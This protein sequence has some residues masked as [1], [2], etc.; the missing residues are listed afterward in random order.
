MGKKPQTKIIA[1]NK[2]AYFN[3]DLLETFE[4]GISLLGS[5]VKSIREGRISLKESYA[6]LKDGEVFLLHCHISPYEAANRYNHEPRRERKLLLHKREIKRLTGKIKEKGLT[7]IPTKVLIN[8][9]GKVKVE[10]SLAKGK[11]TYQKKEA[12]KE[13]DVQREV[14][15]ELKKWR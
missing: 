12:I 3:Y 4:A 14:R 1:K 10:I 2:K 5:E 15:A 13:R 9:K 11:R 6:E 7:L 8:A